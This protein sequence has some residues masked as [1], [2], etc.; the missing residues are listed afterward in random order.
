VTE[1]EVHPG[2]LRVVACRLILVLASECEAISPHAKRSFAGRQSIVHGA[3]LLRHIVEELRGLYIGVEKRFA[4]T[5]PNLDP[6]C[7]CNFACPRL[8][9]RNGDLEVD[10]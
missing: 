1:S 2:S 8:I 5:R 3:A 10:V 9:V 4:R 7:R 6:P